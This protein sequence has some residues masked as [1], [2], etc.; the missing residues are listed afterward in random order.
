MPLSEIGHWHF[1]SG[2]MAGFLQNTMGQIEV[3]ANFTLAELKAMPH[4]IRQGR[5]A[6]TL[7]L[8]P[9]KV[10]VAEPPLTM[11]GF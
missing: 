5:Q 6:I 1:E 9:A 4:A 8:V 7:A 10:G 2:Q 11:T 3:A